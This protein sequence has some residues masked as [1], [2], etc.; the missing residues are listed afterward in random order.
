MLEGYNS[1]LFLADVM[2]YSTMLRNVGLLQAFYE[3]MKFASRP[4]VHLSLQ[5]SRILYIFEVDYFGFRQ[6][7]LTLPPHLYIIS[8]LLSGYQLAV[9]GDWG[10]LGH[11]CLTQKLFCDLCAI[12]SMIPKLTDLYFPPY[13]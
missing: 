1:H 12:W 7:L 10:T 2:I 13:C 6:Y 3:I 8:D 11:D 9:R 5:L 4:S